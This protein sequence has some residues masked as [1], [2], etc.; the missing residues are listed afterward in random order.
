MATNGGASTWSQPEPY[1][2]LTSMGSQDFSNLPDLDVNFDFDFL[3]DFDPAN[4]G[5]HAGKLAGSIDSDL[6]ATSAQQQHAVHATHHSSAR[7]TMAQTSPIFDVGMHYSVPNGQPFTGMQIGHNALGL[8]QMVPPTPNSVEMHANAAHY[9]QQ[10]DAQSR[11]MMDHYQM[12][13]S[14]AVSI[15]RNYHHFNNSSRQ[16]NNFTPLGTPAVTPHEL[17]NNDYTVPGTY[18]SPL[19]SPMLDGQ[20]RNGQHTSA[21][22]GATVSPIDHDVDMIRDSAPQADFATKK[23]VKKASRSLRINGNRK[24]AQ[25]PIQ[26]PQRKK[27]AVL[28]IQSREMNEL[29]E[30]TQQSRLS[31]TSPRKSLI[32]QSNSTS[33][34]S[35][36]PEPLTE[37][38]GPPPKPAS[39]K[40]SPAI[41]GKSPNFAAGARLNS[42][43]TPAS[44][45]RLQSNGEATDA[46]TAPSPIHETGVDVPMLEELALPEAVMSAPKRPS[47]PRI[48]TANT[49]G[50]VTPRLGARGGTKSGAITPIIPSAGSASTKHTPTNSAVTSPTNVLASPVISKQGP[51]SK[52]TKKRG[53]MSSNVQLSPAIRPKI[54]I[55]PNIQPLLP[56]GGPG[57][58]S[59]QE[60]T[61]FLASRSNYQNLIEG[62]NI[63]GVS[64][65][66]DLPT[67]LTS[68]RTSHK[69]AE[70]GRRQRI[71][72]ALQKMQ[73][74]LPKSLPGEK[75]GE[76]DD[77]DDDDEDDDNGKRKGSGGG[78]G[79]GNSK[80][81]TVESA[82]IYIEQLQLQHKQWE[83]GNDARER[84]W[85]AK[86]E[87][88][89]K[90]LAELKQ[91]VKELEEKLAAVAATAQEAIAGA[92]NDVND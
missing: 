86:Q 51:K 58:L 4:S 38:M 79:G 26:K 22:S 67:Q 42:P 32:S 72:I 91:K 28:A 37:V 48:D 3:N 62:T 16:M 7:L 73:Q 29:L 36:S 81:A 46:V 11:A 55:S 75:K 41:L 12:Q 64:Y 54:S 83:E 17:I 59:D 2:A 90:Q 70:Q 13:K 76:N 49:S 66:S 39:A 27:T 65:P 68:K 63:P 33:S 85:V 19:A 74:L 21:S 84:Q 44:L 57:V 89:Q 77:E 6:Y 78:K 15:A 31:P 14:D 60:R 18:F 24:V 23:P 40:P 56:G 88:D 1:N 10:M 34:D 25:S 61:T 92:T 43:A 47:V 20:S 35:I 87:A 8:Q 80:A 5:D 52:I 50:D 69:I 45:M 53:S 9:M 30:A 71:N 82:I